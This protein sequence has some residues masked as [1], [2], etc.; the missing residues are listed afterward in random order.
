MPLK[1]AMKEFSRNNF[2]TCYGTFYGRKPD[3]TDLTDTDILKVQSF[4]QVPSFALFTEKVQQALDRWQK[5][6]KNNAYVKTVISM[7]FILLNV[8]FRCS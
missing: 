1:Q 6:E 5:Q 8:F 2:K 4:S 3:L 7:A